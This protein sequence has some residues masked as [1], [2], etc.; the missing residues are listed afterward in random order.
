MRHALTGTCTYTDMPVKGCT[1]VW[2][3]G[4]GG[5]ERWNGMDWWTGLDWTGLEW[6]GSEQTGMAEQPIASKLHYVPAL[7]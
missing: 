1:G 3:F 5:L 6:T 4:F 2:V 7:A